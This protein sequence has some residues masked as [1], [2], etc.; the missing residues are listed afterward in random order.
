MF[1]WFCAKQC[2]P[3]EPLCLNVI[4]NVAFKLSEDY[5]PTF[6][7]SKNIVSHIDPQRPTRQAEE[8][9]ILFNDLARSETSPRT[10]TEFK[11][12]D[13]VRRTLRNGKLKS[14]SFVS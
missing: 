10:R 2:F 13:C 5:C 9:Q 14:I 4:E 8:L 6:H 3:S 11:H 1:S 7:T 12:G